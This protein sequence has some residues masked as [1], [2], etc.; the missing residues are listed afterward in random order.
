MIHEI[1]G[2]ALDRLPPLEA[3]VIVAMPATDRQ[4]ARLTAGI[5]ERRAG[6]HALAIVVVHDDDRRGFVYCANRVF[7]ATRGTYF[8]YLAQ[9]AFP[10]RQWLALGLGTLKESGGKLLAFNDGKWAG[11]MAAFGLV[12]R[13]WAAANSAGGT[14]FDPGYTSHYADAELTVLAMDQGVYRYNANA[15]LVEVDY[16]KDGRPANAKDKASYRQRAST[17]F[18]G[19]ITNKELATY[20]S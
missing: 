15:V 9:D 8:A 5:L 1:D 19:R 12:E 4:Q 7:A 3:E 18:E 6:I 16:E 20:V 10:G 14:L 17:L 11:G 2:A 13:Q